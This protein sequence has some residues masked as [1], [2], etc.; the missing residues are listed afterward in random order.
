MNYS[1]WKDVAEFIGVT[2][3]VASLIFVGVQLRQD[4]DIA[5]TEILA[6][7]QAVEL[8]FASLVQ[9][10]PEIWRKGLVGEPLSAEE[11]VS[12]DLMA[13]ALFRLYANIFRR[14]LVFEG[15]TGFTDLSI[16]RSFAFFIYGNPGLRAWFDQLVE[17]R[18]LTQRAYGL[19]DE[20]RAYPAVVNELLLQ[21]DEGVFEVPE[22]SFFPY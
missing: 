19:P 16:S 9:A 11:E 20:I 12:F 2:A 4:R 22:K 15:L 6:S 8:D 21:L 7:D 17:T 10:E 5:E 1:R 14:G 18:A 13:Y 3:I